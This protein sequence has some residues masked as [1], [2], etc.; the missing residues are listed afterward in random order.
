MLINF[1]PVSVIDWLRQDFIGQ[2]VIYKCA[3]RSRIV[4]DVNIAAAGAGDIEQESCL[5]IRRCVND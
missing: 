1:I 2:F 4:L 3:V 5:L